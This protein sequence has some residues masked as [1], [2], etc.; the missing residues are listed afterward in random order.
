MEKGPINNMIKIIS[1]KKKKNHSP[2]FINNKDKTIFFSL[3]FRGVNLI[4]IRV[5]VMWC[6]M[7]DYIR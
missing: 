7:G 1:K 4:R 3:D 6:R 5:I 2:I